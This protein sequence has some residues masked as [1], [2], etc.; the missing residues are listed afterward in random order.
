M[1]HKQGRPGFSDSGLFFI[2]GYS[3]AGRAAV[4]K[5][6]CRGFESYY[7]CQ[8]N[9]YRI[10]GV[11]F[12]RY[13]QES[14]PEARGACRAAQPSAAGGGYSEAGLAQRSATDKAT[15]Y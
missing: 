11:R 8:R 10:S 3:S 7:P 2:Q 13:G 12:F 4:S 6:A 1:F 14:E 9:G 15:L 5:T